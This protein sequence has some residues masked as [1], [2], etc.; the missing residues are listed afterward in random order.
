MRH[1]CEGGQ[2]IGWD[3]D[4]RGGDGRKDGVRGRLSRYLFC[5]LLLI[6]SSAQAHGFL[7]ANS[8]ALV[9]FVGD[10]IVAVV[11]H[12]RR[13]GVDTGKQRTRRA[14]QSPRDA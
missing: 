12:R 14:R 7:I 11:E 3:D 4:G 10:E 13:D 1:R 9:V 2:R 5:L 6:L 8:S